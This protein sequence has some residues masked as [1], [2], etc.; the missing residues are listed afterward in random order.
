MTALQIYALV[1]PF[2]VLAIGWAGVLYWTKRTDREDRRAK[3]SR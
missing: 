1:V 2:V 3:D